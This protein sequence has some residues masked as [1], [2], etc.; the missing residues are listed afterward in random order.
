MEAARS[1]AH[2]VAAREEKRRAAEAMGID[3]A[4]VSDLV[5]RFYARIREDGLLGPIFAARIEDWAPHLDQMKR[6]WRSVLFSSGEFLGNPMARHLAIPELDRALFER[7]LKLFDATLAEL[8][9]EA[10]RAHVLERARLIANSLLNGI[11]I[12]HHGRIG[13]TAGEA[14]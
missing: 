4:F 9:G 6:F 1:S 13:L 10:A 14:L 11:A 5:D 8:G 3:E 2:A 12:H 7:W